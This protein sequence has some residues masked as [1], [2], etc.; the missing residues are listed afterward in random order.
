MTNVISHE[1]LASALAQAIA[2]I[3][4]RVPRDALSMDAMGDWSELVDDILPRWRQLVAQAASAPASKD[5]AN[6]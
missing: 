6:G 3:E 1:D 2:L 4:Q 5:N